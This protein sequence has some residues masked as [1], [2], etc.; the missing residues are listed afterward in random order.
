MNRRPWLEA[1][2]DITP[3]FIQRSYKKGH[4]FY[5]DDDATLR[6]LDKGEASICVPTVFTIPPGGGAGQQA[7]TYI[8]SIRA[9]L[10]GLTEA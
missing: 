9:R 8:H 5:T 10:A 7:G 3:Y 6:V 2:E 1:L 4:V